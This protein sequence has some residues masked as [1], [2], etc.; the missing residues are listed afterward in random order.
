MQI[1]KYFLSMYFVPNP[2]HGTSTCIIFWNPHSHSRCKWC[3]SNLYDY[4]PNPFTDSAYL[5]ENADPFRS[6]VTPHQDYII[7]SGIHRNGR[8]KI[9]ENNVAIVYLPFPISEIPIV[10]SSLEGGDKEE[11]SRL[12]PE[13]NLQ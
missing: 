1:C 5:G 8:F 12:Y 13:A 11:G 3:E 10:Q 6:M 4:G 7:L 2:I 9:N